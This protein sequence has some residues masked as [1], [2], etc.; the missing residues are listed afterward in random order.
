MMFGFSAAERDAANAKIAVRKERILI[1]WDT[2]LGYWKL[3]PVG[4][5]CFQVG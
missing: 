1:W 2:V 5:P 4:Q 3:Q